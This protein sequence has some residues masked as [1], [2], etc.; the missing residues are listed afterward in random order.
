LDVL[1]S[2]YFQ[3]SLHSHFGSIYENTLH[4]WQIEQ[5]SIT[6]SKKNTALLQ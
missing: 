3:Q 5:I 1:L 6:T 4:H 2:F